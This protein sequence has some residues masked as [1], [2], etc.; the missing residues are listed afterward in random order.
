MLLELGAFSRLFRPR[1]TQDK[2]NPLTRYI[3]GRIIF[4][5]D[6]HCALET[7][8]CD[9]RFYPLAPEPSP[10][11]LQTP[12][13]EPRNAKLL[14]GHRED[15]NWGKLPRRPFYP[16]WKPSSLAH[17]PSTAAKPRRGITWR[18]RVA[19]PCAFPSPQLQIPQPPKIDDSSP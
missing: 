18:F 14:H 12:Q 10:V 17:K 4:T 2:S 3:H 6:V 11:H 15:G 19:G 16:G 8:T 5:G 7:S 9:L 1:S 13:P